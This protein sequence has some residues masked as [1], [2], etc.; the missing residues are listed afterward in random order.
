MLIKLDA[1]FKVDVW[2]GAPPVARSSITEAASVVSEPLIELAAPLAILSRPEFCN[3]TLIGRY[4][5][6]DSELPGWHS[7]E[8][9]WA[10]TQGQHAWYKAMENA[11]ELTQINDLA[12][13]REHLGKWESAASAELPIGYLLTLEGADS[14]ISM[15]HLEMSY[16]QGLRAVGPAHYGDGVYAQGTDATPSKC[17]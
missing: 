1:T 2:P 14:I 9:A 6:P 13:L 7:Q 4:V 3:A 10:Q 16:E 15:E 12:T 8:Q 11:G 17:V 5:K